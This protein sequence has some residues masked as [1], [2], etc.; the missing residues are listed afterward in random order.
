MKSG[1]DA[2]IAAFF[3]GT[4]LFCWATAM[5]AVS[6]MPGNNLPPVGLWQFDKIAHFTEYFILA[7]LLFRYL[8]INWHFPAPR[9]YFWCVAFTALF[10]ALDEIHQ[11][12]IPLRYC[13]WQDFAADSAGALAGFFICG[14]VTGK[15]G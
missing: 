5:L 8:R 4:M 11:M 14:I 6:S 2:R 3:S 9:I 13:T 7:I 10:G 15:R 1:A 12:F